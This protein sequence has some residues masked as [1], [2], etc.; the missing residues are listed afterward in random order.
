MERHYFEY[1]Q[2]LLVALGFFITVDN[3]L[4]KKSNFLGI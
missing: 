2:S 4:V 3:T 1:Q